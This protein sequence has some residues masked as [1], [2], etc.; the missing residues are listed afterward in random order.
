MAFLYCATLSYRGPNTSC[1]VS[2]YVYLPLPL[3]PKKEEL[4]VLSHRACN[5]DSQSL[6]YMLWEEWDG[7][8]GRPTQEDSPLMYGSGQGRRHKNDSLK[9][10]NLL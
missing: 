4:H 2:D 8:K 9:S 10:L 6:C 1:P 3:P 5:T 7:E